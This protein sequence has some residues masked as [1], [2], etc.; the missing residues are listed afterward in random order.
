[1]LVIAGIILLSLSSVASGESFKLPEGIAVLSDEEVRMALVGNQLSGVNNGMEWSETF[2]P[3]GTI[4]G[5]W[6]A[7]D[8]IGSWSLS[9]SVLCLDYEGSRS[10]SCNAL[11][12]DGEGVIFWKKDG[13]RRAEAKLSKGQ[14]STS[15]GKV[16]NLSGEWIFD[17]EDA[18]YTDNQPAIVVNQEGNELQGYWANLFKLGQTRCDRGLKWFAGSF[19]S[20]TEL[21][22]D[23]WTCGGKR[24]DLDAT[25]LDDGRI[26]IMV[27]TGDGK[28]I[29]TWLIRYETW[30]DK[31]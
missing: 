2:L 14:A 24:N 26:R 17:G 10:D 31:Q 30:L 22:G 13:S 15:F 29:P 21:E 3:Y 27:R 25:I 20:K 18:K 16:P 5:K 7:K 8:Y 1:M 19:D 6:G 11:S 9:E 28:R 12:L 4:V 23:R